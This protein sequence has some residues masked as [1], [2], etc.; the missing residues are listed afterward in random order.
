MRVIVGERP[1]HSM[2]RTPKAFASTLAPFRNKLTHSLP[3]IR[4]SARPSMSRRFPR[5]PFSV[6]ATTPSTPSRFPASLVRFASSRSRTPAVLFF[7][8]SHG[9]SPSR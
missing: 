1:N 2:E 4:P 5:A 8:D 7:N 9:L 6:F 3:L